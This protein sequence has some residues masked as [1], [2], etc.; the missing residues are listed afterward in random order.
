M[1]LKY[2]EVLW[3]FALS[4]VLLATL[5]ER[6]IAGAASAAEPLPANYRGNPN[7]ICRDGLVV[8]KTKDGFTTVLDSKGHKTTCPNQD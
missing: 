3:F 7:V 8:L 5:P 1:L 6:Q 2:W 4:V